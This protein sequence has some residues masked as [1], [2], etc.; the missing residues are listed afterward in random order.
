MMSSTSKSVG[1]SASPKALL[2]AKQ[3]RKLAEE[4]AVRLANRIEQLKKEEMKALKKISDTRR[5][6]EEIC[7][8]RE[9][10]TRQKLEKQKREIEKQ[11]EVAMQAKV[12][13]RLKREHIE[14][15]LRSQEILAKQKGEAVIQTKVARAANER[16]KQEQLVA[17][18][19]RALEMKA[20]VR[21]QQKMFRQK[22]ASVKALHLQETHEQYERRTLKELEMKEHKEKELEKMAKLEMELIMT[23]QKRQKEQKRAVRE[24]E[25]ALANEAGPGSRSARTGSSRAASSLSGTVGRGKSKSALGFRAGSAASANGKAGDLASSAGFEPSDDEIKASFLAMDSYEEAMLPSSPA[26]EALDAAAGL[27]GTDKGG[28]K[29]TIGAGDIADLLKKLGLELNEQQVD[30][31]KEQLDPD[32]SGRVQYDSFLEWWHG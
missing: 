4:D 9:R 28:E 24:L 22:A 15:K 3:L 18:R 21:E 2:Q 29:D 31:C 12:M 1:A 32:A 10:N 30:Q 11:E 23:L 16:T 8:L 7:L 25:A 19:K 6:A 5:R 17:D 26:D 20:K 14:K 13:R 27:F